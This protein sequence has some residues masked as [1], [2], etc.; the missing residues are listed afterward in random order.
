M[1]Q[2]KYSSGWQSSEGLLEFSTVMQTLDFVSGLHNCLEFSQPLSGHANT[3]NVFYCLNLEFN[4]PNKKN[5][6]E[7]NSFINSTFPSLKIIFDKLIDVGNAKPQTIT[8]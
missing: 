1:A 2:K 8:S 7:I 3:E 4:K 6:Y 5:V